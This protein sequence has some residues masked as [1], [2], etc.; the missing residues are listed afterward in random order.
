M[1]PKV[2]TA[3][4]T[5][6]TSEAFTPLSGLTKTVS[7]SEVGEQIVPFDFEVKSVSGIQTVEILVE[8]A[9]ERATYAIEIDVE[10]PNLYTQTIKDV[11]L[12]ASTP[13]T[14]DYETFGEAGTN[15]STLEFSTL[16]PMDFAKRLEYLIRYPYGCV[17][18]TTS[19]AFPQ[20]YLEELFDMT[21]AQKQKTQDNIKATINRLGHFQ[22]PSGGL[23]YWPGENRADDWGTTYAG[24]FMIEARRKG[25]GLPLSFMSNWLAYQKRAARE[26]RSAGTG[27]TTTLVQAYRLYTLALA[28]Q[29][30]LA[31]MN[32]L[33]EYG[34]LRNDARWRLAAAYAVVGQVQIA[35]EIMEKA[36]IDFV[37]RP[38]DYRT[39]GS[40]FRNRAMALE[41]MVILGD[42]RQQDLAVSIAKRLSSK[43]WLSTQETSY[44]LLALGKMIIKNGGKNVHIGYEIAGKKET[45][46][47]PKSIAL[48]E[49]PVQ[50]G[51]NR[52]QLTNEGGNRIYVRLVQSGKLPLGQELEENR[53]LKISTSYIDADGEKVNIDD[54]RQ[55]TE[56]FAEVRV[57]NDDRDRINNV[58][59]TQIFPSGW[60]IVNTRFATDGNYEKA[61]ARYTDIRDDRIHQYFDMDATSTKVFRV[62]LNASFLGT[63]YLPGSQVEAMYDNT[64]YARNKGQWITVRE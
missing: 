17:E 43:Y 64:Y 11:T 30:D 7:F 54:L 10:N 33:R 4:I 41:T 26:W 24:H 40:V 62:R 14:L 53:K 23:G 12:E 25:Y 55:G 60:E 46:R 18:Q 13:F 56:F 61:T 35:N 2:K 9:G 1:E 27:Y 47:T 31:A 36:S 8:G 19:S 51:T 16:P 34:N 32:R 3:K 52:I 20:L 50:D 37:E 28:E 63:Y 21:V 15:S 57:H 42:N 29:P 49:V 48:R 44:A 45:I 22:N 6:K 59:L 5:I 58:A 39:Y 38:N